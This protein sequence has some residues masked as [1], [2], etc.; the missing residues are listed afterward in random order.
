[1][2]LQIKFEEAIAVAGF[3]VFTIALKTSQI[4]NGTD[5]SLVWLS[6]RKS[7]VKESFFV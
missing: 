2:F 5:A 4:T 7:F 6:F 3:K 1:M